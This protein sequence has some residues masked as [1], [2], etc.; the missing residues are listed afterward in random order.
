VFLRPVPTVPPYS[1]QTD[2]KIIRRKWACGSGPGPG[3]AI[4]F[5]RGRSGL[6]GDGD[7]EAECLDLLDVVLQPAVGVEARLVVAGA[8]VG[9]PVGGILQ[10]VPDDDQDGAGDGDLDNDLPRQ[11]V[12][13]FSRTLTVLSPSRRIGMAGCLATT[14]PYE[15]T[16]D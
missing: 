9:E 10:Q 5:G 11:R 13:A 14:W 3:S 1:V 12:G 15:D 16:Q 2:R 6:R 4:G 7:G 8:E